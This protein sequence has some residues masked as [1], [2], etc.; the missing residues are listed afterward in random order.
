MAA[1]RFPNDVVQAAWL[2]SGGK[3]ECMDFV[4][5]RH[6]IVPHGRILSFD[7]QGKDDS[8]QGWE[9]HHIDPDGEPSLKNCKIL[10]IECHKN[11]PSFGTGRENPIV[12][13]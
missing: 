4:R 2:R 6:S 7:A 10:C 1:T 3:C 11:T 12:D 13:G 8:A 9:A 5:C